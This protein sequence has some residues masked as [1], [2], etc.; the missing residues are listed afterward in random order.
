MYRWFSDV[1]N[2]VQ[3]FLGYL[4]PARH[5]EVTAALRIELC[6][7]AKQFIILGIKPY[8]VLVNIGIEFVSPQNFSD[9]DE[10]VV[11]I[12]TMKKGFLPENLQSMHQDAQP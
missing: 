5:Q 9:L 10:L 6:L 8:V 2:L 4:V 3:G 7:P 1:M 12:V 11:V